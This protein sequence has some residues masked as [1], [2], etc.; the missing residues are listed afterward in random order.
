MIVDFSESHAANLG[1]EQKQ[2]WAN[3]SIATMASCTFFMSLLMMHGSYN[4]KYLSRKHAAKK[5]QT[6]NAR[7]NLKEIRNMKGSRRREEFRHQLVDFYISNDKTYDFPPGPKASGGDPICPRPWIVLC[8]TD[9]IV[10]CSVHR[11]H[12]SRQRYTADDLLV[13][14]Q[15]GAPLS[16]SERGEIYALC[17]SMGYNHDMPLN[18]AKLLRNDTGDTYVQVRRVLVE[19]GDV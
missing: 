19:G 17:E 1:S 10:C 9:R 16:S 18:T 3:L 2:Y 7:H 6:I 12:S 14:V 5:W 15:T 13:V 11:I 8:S 4:T